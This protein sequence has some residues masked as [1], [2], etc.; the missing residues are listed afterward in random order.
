MSDDYGQQKFEEWFR[1]VY[2]RDWRDIKTDRQDDE[3][4]TARRAWLSGYFSG[5]MEGSL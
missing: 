1:V 4:M 5:R 2:G 3:S